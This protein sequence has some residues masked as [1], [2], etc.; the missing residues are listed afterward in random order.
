MSSANIPHLAIAR[1]ESIA[2][3]HL[4]HSVPTPPSSNQYGSALP[5]QGYALPFR[6]EREL[7][8]TLAFLSYTKDDPDRIPAVCIKQN[9]AEASLHV[10]IAVNKHKS[11]DGSVML[12]E[13]EQSFGNIF[14]ILS[15]ASTRM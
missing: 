2:L 5:E 14:A 7:T 10:L 4:L 13:L 9:I 6:K 12:R 1:A 8:S 3:L 15:H 11:K